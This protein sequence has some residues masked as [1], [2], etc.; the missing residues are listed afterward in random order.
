MK[1]FTSVITHD[2]L[3]LYINTT[4]VCDITMK[5]KNNVV[6]NSIYYEKFNKNNR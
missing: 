3:L 6:M 2:Y 5:E 1:H 4:A